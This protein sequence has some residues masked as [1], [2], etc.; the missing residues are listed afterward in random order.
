[1]KPRS[2]RSQ[3]LPHSCWVARCESAGGSV[4]L[5]EDRSLLSNLAITDAFLVN[6]YNARIASPVLGE[7]LEVRSLY[8]TRGLSA[9]DTYAIRVVVDSIAIDREEVSFGAGTATGNWFADVFHGYAESGNHSIQVILDPFNQVIEDNENDNAFTFSMTPVPATS[10]PQKLG[11]F[12][13]GTAGVDWRVSNFADLD[14]RP[15]FLRDYRGGKFTY[16]TS[17]FGHDAIDVGSGRFSATDQGVAIYAAADGK[18]SAINDGAFDRNTAFVTPAPP[19]NYVVID[20]GKGWRAKYWHL[21]R[22]SVSVKVGDTIKAGDFLGWMGSSGFSAG[23][24]VHFE[25]TYNKHPVETMLDPSRFWITP[26]A[27]PA[28]Y[29]HVIDSGFSHQIPTTSE[30]NEQPQDIRTFRSGVSLYFWVIAGAMLPGDTRTIRFQRP[31]GSLFL[32]QTSNP[33]SVSFSVSQWSYALN[34][35][36]TGAMGTWTATWLQN[37]LELARE[38]FDVSNSG[39]PEVRVEQGIQTILTDRFTPIDFG[40]VVAGSVAPTQTFTISNPGSAPLSLSAVQLPA[41]YELV[42]V[43]ATTVL[44]GQTTTLKIRLKTTVAGYF[45]GEL[46][47]TTNDSDESVFRF[48]LEGII[49]T[50]GLATLIPGISIRKTSEGNRFFAN[51]RRTGNTATALTVALS[52]DSSELKIPSTITIPAGASFANFEVQAVQDFA[53]D[54]DQRVYLRASATG[55]RPGRNEVLVQDVF[56][57]VF[58]INQSSNSTEVSQSSTS[59]QIQSALSA[60]PATPVID[61]PDSFGTFLDRPLQVV[62]V[63][64]L[65]YEPATPLILSAS[66][67]LRERPLQIELSPVENAVV[68]DVRIDFASGGVVNLIRMEVREPTL[69]FATLREMGLFGRRYWGLA[70]MNLS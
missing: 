56:A 22:D 5:L 7:Q 45:A 46:R 36:T 13:H 19:A 43:P 34:L 52:T 54:G 59:S 24:H 65:D 25:M 66:T 4:E 37:G 26:P 41:G 3:F 58:F 29:R 32:D 10:F 50:P 51:V 21:R 14:P 61:A 38:S 33:G 2:R 69:M 55:L 23:P 27:Y 9:S 6:G 16:D 70:P 35:P 64:I 28:D 1:M 8:S 39:V 18:I 57:G 62:T 68:Y 53:A 60:T 42:M 12:V 20:L 63:T 17:T 11:T 47:M 15:G 48:W 30:W 67:A 31:D 49:E 40:S 44:P